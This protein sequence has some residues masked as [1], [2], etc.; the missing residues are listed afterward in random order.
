VQPS[1]KEKKASKFWRLKKGQSPEKKRPGPK[2]FLKK[3]K[4]NRIHE[5]EPA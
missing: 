3:M 5:D 2:Y 4:E 1:A